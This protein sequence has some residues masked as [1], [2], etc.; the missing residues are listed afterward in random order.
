MLCRTLPERP[1]LS[2]FVAQMQGLKGKGFHVYSTHTPCSDLGKVDAYL[3]A[4]GNCLCKREI[5]GWPNY[6]M[7]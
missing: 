4:W 3:V 2:F 7:I 1:V 5:P 6:K